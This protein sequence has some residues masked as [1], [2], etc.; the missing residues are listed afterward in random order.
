MTPVYSGYMSILPVVS[1]LSMISDEPM[2]DLVLT[3]KPLARRAC[4]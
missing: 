2:F 4:A 1:A 3:V